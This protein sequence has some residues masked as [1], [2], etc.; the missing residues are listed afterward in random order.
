MKLTEPIA[1]RQSAFKGLAEE[2]SSMHCSTIYLDGLTSFSKISADLF[3]IWLHD[4][5]CPAKL[6]SISRS[7]LK[8]LRSANFGISPVR[9]RRKVWRNSRSN[10]SLETLFYW[11]LRKLAEPELLQDVGATFSQTATMP[12]S[13]GPPG[14]REASGV[15]AMVQP[16]CWKL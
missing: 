4:S 5:R 3:H 10:S 6:R 9:A 12:T 7:R 11:N 8:F 14:L 1:N 2:Y 13:H 15:R 16:P